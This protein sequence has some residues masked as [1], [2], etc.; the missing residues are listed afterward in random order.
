MIHGFQKNMLSYIT[1]KAHWF[2][3]TELQ[4]SIDDKEKAEKEVV[5]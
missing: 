2:N 5:K 3:F 1:N 4:K